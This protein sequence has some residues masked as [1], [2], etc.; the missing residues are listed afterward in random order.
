ML[1]EEV[2]FKLTFELGYFLWQ[3]GGLLEVCKVEGDTVIVGFVGDEQDLELNSV[4]YWEPV[5]MFED[6][7]YVFSG[8]G[9]VELSGSRVLNLLEFME[10]GGG[11]AVENA[12][13]FIQSG[14]YE[15]VN[16]CF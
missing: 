9:M 13:A 16:E 12:V 1:L 14:G 5:K 11:E 15:G 6:G 8:A 3:I 2:G 4:V 10:V 7:S